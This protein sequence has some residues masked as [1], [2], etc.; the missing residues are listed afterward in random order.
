MIRIY[1]LIKTTITSCLVLVSVMAWADDSFNFVGGAKVSMGTWEGKN[2]VPDGHAFKTDGQVLGITAGFQKGKWMGAASVSFGGFNFSGSSP[3]KAPIPEYMNIDT[4]NVVLGE[5]DLAFG[6]RIWPRLYPIFGFKRF[7]MTWDDPVIT[8]E[9]VG[10][11]GGISGNYPLGKRTIVFG[12][13]AFENMNITYQTDDI[14]DAT[15]TAIEI[16]TAYYFS[17]RSLIQL[18]LEAHSLE[19]Q[20]QNEVQQ[21]HNL[22]MLT[23]G[24]QY[25]F[26][27]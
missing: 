24:Y 1:R 25:R 27:D 9:Y 11:S 22:R 8:Q 15:G 20:Y 16:G 7:G 3:D 17:P 10:Y 14:G 5:F 4:A 13:I 12:S 18:T 26:G 23:L 6:Y 2:N 19:S 21:A